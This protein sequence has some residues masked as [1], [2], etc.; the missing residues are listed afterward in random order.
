MGGSGLVV[1]RRVVS[2]GSARRGTVLQLE[3]PRSNRAWAKSI[4]A[5]LGS[6][7]ALLS[8]VCCRLPDTTGEYASGAPVVVSQPQTVCWLAALLDQRAKESGRTIPRTHIMGQQQTRPKANPENDFP[9]RRYPTIALD[10]VFP[11][12]RARKAPVYASQ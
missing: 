8:C 1:P 5:G 12:C 7:I 2:P 3:P 6:V 10:E 11:D 9:L 4:R